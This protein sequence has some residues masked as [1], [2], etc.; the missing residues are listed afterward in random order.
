LRADQPH[1]LGPGFLILRQP[2]LLADEDDSP[3][4]SVAETNL[5]V[6][7]PGGVDDVGEP[8]H[9]SADGSSRSHQPHRSDADSASRT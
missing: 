4:R 2:Q 8:A 5:V 3:A 1:L 9:R 6:V 7:W